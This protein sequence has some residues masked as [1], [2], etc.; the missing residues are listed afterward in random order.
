MR[1]RRRV[2][3]LVEISYPDEPGEDRVRAVE[4]AIDILQ[5]FVG[6]TGGLKVIEIERATGISRPTLYRLLRTLEKRRLVRTCSDPTRYD[7]DYGVVELAHTWLRNADFLSRTEPALQM[8]ADITE[9]TVCLCLYRDGKRVYVRELASKHPLTVARGVGATMPVTIGASGIAILAAE[10]D[11][12]LE[13]VLAPLPPSE[14]ADLRA[15]VDATRKRGYAIT[16]APAIIPGA[17]A[18]SAAIVDHKGQV[19]GSIGVYGPSS[20]FTPDKFEAAARGAIACAKQV[21][22]LMA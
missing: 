4:R 6:Q 22:I 9:E 2:S 14:Q 10:S 18:V 16:S 3:E 17:A 19:Q 5:A 1:K 12:G 13:A 8:L 15:L 21:S 7:L 11:A 20:R